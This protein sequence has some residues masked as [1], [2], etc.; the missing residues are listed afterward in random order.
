MTQPVQRPLDD[1]AAACRAAV[2]AI[3]ALP[4]PEQAFHAG[5]ELALLLQRLNA[6][7]A[8][9][10]AR[11]SLRVNDA[12]DMDLAALAA[13]VSRPDHR[14]GRS[15]MGQMLQAGRAQVVTS[16]NTPA[17]PETPAKE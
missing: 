4:D 1:V 16:G 17:A 11:L 8:A 14:I 6:E 2:A 10:R 5:T 12:H 3:E 13:H 15:R 9:A 7:V